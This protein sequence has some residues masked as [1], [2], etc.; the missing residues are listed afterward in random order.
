MSDDSVQPSEPLS[1]AQS[2]ISSQYA[3]FASVGRSRLFFGVVFDMKMLVI[4]TLIFENDI[5]FPTQPLLHGI[6]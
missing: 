1:R 6:A 5:E 2:R 4:A 3:L